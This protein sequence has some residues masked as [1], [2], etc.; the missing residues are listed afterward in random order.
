[1]KPAQKKTEPGGEEKP[2]PGAVVKPPIGLALSPECF[3][4]MTQEVCSFP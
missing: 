3:S 4:Y 1:M 2:S